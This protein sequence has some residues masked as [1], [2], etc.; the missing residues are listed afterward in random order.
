[1]TQLTRQMQSTRKLQAEMSMKTMKFFI[2]E[3]SQWRCSMKKLLCVT[4][5]ITIAITM[6]MTGCATR[7][8]TPEE[9]KGVL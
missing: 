8:Y 7:T 5:V 4:T 3:I 6:T 1:M 2:T 9:L